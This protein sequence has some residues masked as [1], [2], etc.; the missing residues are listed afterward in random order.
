M[1]RVKLPVHP[2]LGRQAYR[3]L[4]Q[5]AYTSC[6]HE[7]DRT[8]Q[9]TFMPNSTSMSAMRLHTAGT[10]LSLD[11]VA[12]PV[13]RDHEVLLEVLACG[14]CRTDL[15]VVDGELPDTRYP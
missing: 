6:F 3:R 8:H 7:R 10:A 5:L 9:G 12:R 11:S 1:S 4:K 15:H 2:A 13:P 14:V